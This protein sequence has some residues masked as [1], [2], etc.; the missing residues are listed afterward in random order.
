MNRFKTLLTREWMQ[1]RRGFLIVMLA[2]GLLLLAA[3]MFGQMQINLQNDADAQVRQVPEPGLMTALA[4]TGLAIGTMALAWLSALFQAPGLARRDQQD[5]SIDFW[6]S[7]PIGHSQALGSMLLVHLVLLPWAAL[8]I[9]LGAGVVISAVMVIKAWGLGAWLALPWGSLLAVSALVLARVALGLVLCT[10]WLSPLILLTMAASAWLKRW[11]VPVVM[12]IVFGGGQ[13][14]ERLY[15]SRLVWDALAALLAQ[16]GQALIAADRAGHARTIRIGPT[17][18]LGDLLPTLPAWLLHDAALAL[19][20][21][22]SPAF[23]AAA[24]G[25]IAGFGLLVL[26]RARAAG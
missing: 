16:A 17:T 24:L 3:A 13:L 11:G 12:A 4:L 15:G 5:R 25:G 20:A 14:A 7:L 18:Q 2:P 22:A 9:G 1:H 21:L 8:A 10:L 26:H 6:L 19:Q 23:V